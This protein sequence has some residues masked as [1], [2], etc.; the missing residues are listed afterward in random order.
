[1]HLALGTF[2]REQSP[3]HQPALLQSDLR[4]P[5][6]SLLPIPF[7]HLPQFSRT[8]YLDSTE[9][10]LEFRPHV[11]SSPVPFAGNALSS[12]VYL[13]NPPLL[14]SGVG[15]ASSGKPVLSRKVSHFPHGS[16]STYLLQHLL[17]LIVAIGL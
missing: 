1:M 13:R 3:A 2:F 6:Q 15:T 17:P 12:S 14:P 11:F 16:W 5:D 4:P 9:N 10:N 7:S 8:D